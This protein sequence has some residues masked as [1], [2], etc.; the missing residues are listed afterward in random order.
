MIEL[1]AFTPAHEG[2]EGPGN[3]NARSNEGNLAQR[4]LA[5]VH[6]ALQF[7]YRQSSAD[8]LINVTQTSRQTDVE[9]GIGDE[10]HVGP[11]SQDR[12]GNFTT[13]MSQI[14]TL[15]LVSVMLMGSVTKLYETV[16]SVH[17]S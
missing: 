3:G 2:P 12:G 11:G 1:R 8:T 16:S 6:A 17:G 13:V 7:L 4:I 10:Q 9:L 14:I 15:L 5:R